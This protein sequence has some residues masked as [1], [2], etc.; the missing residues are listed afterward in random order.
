MATF[1]KYEAIRSQNNTQMKYWIFFALCG[2]STLSCQVQTTSTS[3]SSNVQVSPVGEWDNFQQVWLENTDT[4]MH[5]VKV[6]KKHRHYHL[7]I[8][9]LA[10]T[11]DSLSI[12]FSAGRNGQEK[13]GSAIVALDQI[14]H[15]QDTLWVDQIAML[16]ENPSDYRFLKC[17]TF[18]GWLQYPMPGFPDS[19]YFQ[20]NLELHD[21]GGM[22]ELDIE[23]V[24]Y[25]VELTQLAYAKTIKIMKLA[26][27]EMPMDSIGINSYAVSYTWTN[28]E[29]KRLGINLRKIV[30]GWTLIE[31][32]YINSNNL[33][34]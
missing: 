4:D 19:T 16:D 25:T 13:L 31:P 28:P 14:R 7:S 6:E 21:Q 20:R 34:Q 3:S 12:T 5:R 18:S 17:R 1:F 30:S 23:G 32:G 11:P 29:A 33:K 27:Y 22:V 26:V 2:F 24:D 10:D 15:K 8:D 9:S